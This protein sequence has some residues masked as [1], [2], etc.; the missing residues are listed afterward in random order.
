MANKLVLATAL[1]GF[2]ALGWVGYTQS[3]DAG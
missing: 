2:V 1:A 3:S